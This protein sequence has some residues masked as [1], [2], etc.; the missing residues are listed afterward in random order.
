MA[1][2]TPTDILTDMQTGTLG[3]KNLQSI[4][5]PSS[6]EFWRWSCQ[7]Y[8]SSSLRNC[9]L[10][11]QDDAK[12]DINLILLLLWM[13][14]HSIKCDSVLLTGLVQASNMLSTELVAL[15]QQR[16]AL[17][18]QPGYEALKTR[19]LDMEKKAQTKLLACLPKTL[20]TPSGPCL[21][22]ED[23][24]RMLDLAQSALQSIRLA[25]KNQSSA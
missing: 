6:E 23:Y 5:A 20:P 22:L 4:D 18:G 25:F 10:A 3:D 2:G 17:K 12:A 24:A 9:L 19:E 16:R 8:S 21:N 15:R 13:E 11:A 7:I 1:S 14:Q